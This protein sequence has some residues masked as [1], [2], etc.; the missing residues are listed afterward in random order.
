MKMRRSARAARRAAAAVELA[1]LLPTVLFP[2]VM[3]VWELGRLV[4]VQQVLDNAVREGARQASTG[5]K[6]NSQVIAAVQQYIT[7]CG[8]G[9][10]NPTVTVTNLT[11]GLDVSQ[12]NQLDHIQI[13][14]TVSYTNIRMTTLS[15]FL[16]ASTTLQA[17]VDWTSMRDL[18]LNVSATIP[19]M[20]Q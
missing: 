15:E 8:M 4:E 13:N 6:N 5:Q 12:A 7:D 9:S 20:P 14:V 1:F 17:S 11:S 3:A 19:S 16:S 18:P 10:S 2:V